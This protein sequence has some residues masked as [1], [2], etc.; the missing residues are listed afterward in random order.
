M[1]ESEYNKFIEIVWQEWLK[2]TGFESRP[3]MERELLKFAVSKTLSHVKAESSNRDRLKIAT[4][5]MHRLF[6]EG[7]QRMERKERLS[8]TTLVLE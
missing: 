3:R 8:S 6:F 4:A 5:A 7:N 1:D 2:A